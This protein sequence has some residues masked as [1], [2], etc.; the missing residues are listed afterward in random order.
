MDPAFGIFGVFFGVTVA[1][2]LIWHRFMKRYI[3]AAFGAGLTVGAI[4]LVS[5]HWLAGVSISEGVLLLAIAMCNSTVVAL[6]VGIPFNRRRNPLQ[7]RS[8]H[9]GIARFSQS[10]SRLD[11]ALLLSLWAIITAIA[12]R[13]A[14]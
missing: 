7:R 12:V 4:V 11:A 8:K 5:L 10:L 6:G 3:P 9:L 2:A 14:P 13:V 1:I